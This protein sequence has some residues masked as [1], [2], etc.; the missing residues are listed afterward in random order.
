MKEVYLD[1]AATTMVD[2]KVVEV[3]DRYQLEEYGNASSS[4]LKGE[5]AR[6]AIEEAREIVA[7]SIGAK[8]KE[9]I[10]TGS[11]TEANNMVIKGLFWANY[12]KKNHIITTKIEHDGILEACQKLEKEGVEVTYL[13]VNENG[14]VETEELKKYIKPNTALVS[15]MYVNNEVGTIQPIA[16]IGKIIAQENKDRS[17]KIVFHTDA[18][19]ALPYV[20]CDVKKLGVDMMSMSAHKIY[21]P[22]GVGAIYIEDG[23]PFS[24]LVFGGHQ[25][26]GIRPGTYNVPGIVGLASAIKLIMDKKENQKEN[27]KL[28][29]LRDMLIEGVL[30]NIDGVLVN[31]DMKKRV[32]SN[33]NF[34]FKGVEGESVL[35]MLSDKGIA[36]STGSACSSGSLEPSHVLS[37]MGVKPELAHGSMRVTLG[38]FNEKSDIEQF[39]KELPPIISRLRKMSPL[40]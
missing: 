29:E 37:A 11:G 20:D 5:A 3:M 30:E 22:K 13:D 36:I 32:P 25:Q 40:K 31:G 24:A 33:A 23:T 1:N 16:E 21:G 17:N 27:K 28:G 26:E 4:H 19:Q 2:E 8:Y 35:L 15:V 38:R 39:V 18:T 7:K 10:F 14:L 34:I 6:R 9:I 12:P